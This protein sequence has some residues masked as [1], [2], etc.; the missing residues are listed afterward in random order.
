GVERMEESDVV[1][2][3]VLDATELD[4]AVT[5]HTVLKDP[6]SDSSLRTYLSGRVKQNYRSRLDEHIEGVEEAA[7]EHGARF[8]QVSTGDD[9]FDS[10]LDVWR[11]VNR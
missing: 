3:N 6:E 8:L 2:V 9:F 1:L 5:G 4:P 10:F 11:D 7:H